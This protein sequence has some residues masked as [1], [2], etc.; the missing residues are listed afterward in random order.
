MPP[1][2]S[3]IMVITL[4]DCRRM[5]FMPAT[6]APEASLEPTAC[7]VAVCRYCPDL[8]SK[9]YRKEYP[10][11]LQALLLGT[12]VATVSDPSCNCTSTLTRSP[13]E[14]LPGLRSTYQPALLVQFTGLV[15][16]VRNCSPLAPVKLLRVC[17]T[18]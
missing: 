2:V 7:A 5:V 4:P 10:P 17:A 12:L 11:T 16:V 13:G 18:S 1:P 14:V 6:M 8:K 3:V 15:D 9:L